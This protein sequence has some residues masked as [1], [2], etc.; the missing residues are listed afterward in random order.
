MHMMQP[1]D[2]EKSC[3]DNGYEPSTETIILQVVFWIDMR[4][5][6]RGFARSVK[7]GAENILSR[8]GHG[9]P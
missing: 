8:S 2:R 4:I 3:G 1:T 5:I 7:P 6:L 9:S